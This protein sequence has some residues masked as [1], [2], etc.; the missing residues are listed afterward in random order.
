MRKPLFLSQKAWSKIHPPL[1]RTPR[2]STQ[3]LNSLTSSFRRQ[4]DHEYPTSAASDRDDESGRQPTESES[5]AHMADKHFTNILGNPLFR[6][7]PSKQKSTPVDLNK[8]SKDPMVFFDEYVASGSVTEKNLAAC[9][10]AQFVASS[11]VKGDRKQAMRTSR[12]GSKVVSWWYAS[13]P[14]VRMQI[15][16]WRVCYR[17]LC[18]FLAA[19]GMQ[20][21]GMAWLKML[22][23][24]HGSPETSNPA[25]DISPYLLSNLVAAEVEHGHGLTSALKYYI[26]A[27]QFLTTSDPPNEEY[28]KHER[29]TLIYGGFWLNTWMIKHGQASVKDIPVSLY[30]EYMRS[31]ASAPAKFLSHALPLY[32]PTHPDTGPFLQNVKNTPLEA[33]GA[34]DKNEIFRESFIRAGFECLRLL[35]DREQF[36][37][38]TDLARYLQQLLPGRSPSTK[39]MPGARYHVSPQE[40]YLLDRLQVTLA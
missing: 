14:N 32:H 18:K 15:F 9:L 7:V 23:R 30:E 33:S 26:Q 37:E 31:V 27:C 10:K 11:T 13:D 36:G 5:S 39:T 22:L 1:P 16:K 8:F 20:D 3:L 34:E 40:E 21:T 35:I 17:Y 6:V 25:K 29:L 38:A 24:P 28:R 2:E 12:A 19:E 4:L